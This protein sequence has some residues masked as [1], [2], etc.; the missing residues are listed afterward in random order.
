MLGDGLGDYT[1]LTL[2]IGIGVL[3]LKNSNMTTIMSSNPNDWA[4][5]LLPQPQPSPCLSRAPYAIT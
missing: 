1:P 2:N 5:V 4:R 3:E